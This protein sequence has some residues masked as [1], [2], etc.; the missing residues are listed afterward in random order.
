M[1]GSA[2]PLAAAAIRRPPVA[3]AALAAVLALAGCGTPA[4]PPY[5]PEAALELFEIHPDFSIELYLAEPGVADPVAMAFGPD[6]RTWVV[7]NSGYPLDTE[8]R[9]GRVRLLQD[10]DGDGRPDASTLFADGLTMPTGVMAWKHGVIVTD[11]PDVLFL[12]DNDGD[13]RADERRRLLGG[14]AFTNPQHTVSSPVYGLDNWIYLANEGPIRSVVFGDEFGDPGEAIHF[15]EAERTRQFDVGRRSLKFRP[16]AFEVEPLAGASQFGLAFSPWGDILTHNNTLHVRHEVIPGRYFRRNP[17]L[18]VPRTAENVYEVAE[19]APVY[20]ITENPRFELLSGM[21]QMTSAAGLT[22]YLGG[23]FPGYEDLTFVA[24]SV[25]NVVHADRW[26]TAGTTFVARPLRRGREFLASR[27]AWFRPVSFSVGPDGALYVV[28]Y[29][30]LVIE[31]PEWTA[32]ETYEAGDLY[33]GSDRGRIWR[34]TPRG[35][36]PYA[37]P[38][39]DSASAEKLVGLLGSR[40]SWQ[41]LAAQ[42]LLVTRNDLGDGRGLRELAVDDADP[43]GR[44]HAL[45]T[46]EGLEALPSGLILQALRSSSAGVRRNAIRLAEGRFRRSPD[47]WEDALVRLEGDPDAKVRLQLLLT[48]GESPSERLRSMRDRMLLAEGDDEWFRVAALT[49][50]EPDPVRLLRLAA[51]ASAADESGVL[52]LES[53]AALAGAGGRSFSTA[54]RIAQGLKDPLRQAA[55]LRG[56][57]NGA[58]A[59][60]RVPPD[61]QEAVLEFA[62]SGD[63]GLRKAALQHLIRIRAVKSPAWPPAIERARRIVRDEKEGEAL[64]ADAIRLLSLGKD[65]GVRDTLQGAIR[66]GEHPAVQAAAIA[67]L[68]LTDPNGSARFL[69]D[70]WPTL[71][72]M[73]RRA[74]GESLSSRAESAGE[75]VNAL[76]AGLVQ[77]WMLEFRSKRRLIMHQDPNLRERARR[78]LTQSEAELGATLQRYRAALSAEPF[79]ESRG[80]KVF[81]DHC[82]DCHRLGGE[83]ADYGPDLAS[84]RTRPALNILHDILLPNESIAQSYESHV[85]HLKHGD[86]A[87]GILHSQEAEFVTLRIE[88]GELLRLDRESIM[89]MR[90]AQLSAMPTDLYAQI[91]PAEMAD[92]VRYIQSAPVQVGLAE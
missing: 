24:E 91:T 55:V 90:P 14:F 58:A 21:G 26:E 52:L 61:I 37:T 53:V 57:H 5:S 67:G 30:R 19:A 7:E 3:R 2:A 64:R 4:G 74:A 92:L 60:V 82:R 9:L 75:L 48:L 65:L 71:P 84:V 78:V 31:H 20:P 6:G 35:G 89:S 69:I 63:A 66:P 42:Q 29:Y 33:D 28:D 44:L 83:G 56:L 40:N 46:L 38:R 1:E 85:V 27:D 47:L 12:A 17:A 88:G 59:E 86:V 68:F 87:E 51:G 81:Q 43:L 73:A 41:R 36:L 16:D 70:R 39:L 45:W 13:G 10:R 50:P 11:A 23:A 80:R 18:R 62:T 54:V 8:G 77:P 34:V 79:D 72:P 22:R 49:W 15:P 32:A 76:E 25:H